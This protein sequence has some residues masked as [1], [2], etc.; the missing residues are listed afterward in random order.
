MV[1]SHSYSR[2]IF[3]QLPLKQRIS[4]HTWAWWLRWTPWSR[5]F[6]VT[7][8]WSSKS[9]QASVAEAMIRTCHSKMHLPALLTS[10]VLHN[11]TR[12]VIR[13]KFS[14]LVRRICFLKS[15][16]LRVLLWTPF[17]AI[18]PHSKNVTSPALPFLSISLSLWSLSEWVA[19]SWY[20]VSIPRNTLVS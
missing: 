16:P 19:G 4:E 2:I 10:I 5:V 9:Y 15:S 6:V 20:D 12:S 13:S 18:V 3:L 11:Y 17:G 8:V 7:A 14:T 1:L